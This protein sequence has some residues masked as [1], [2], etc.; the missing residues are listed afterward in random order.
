M[1]LSQGAIQDQILSWIESPG[2]QSAY[3]VTGTDGVQLQNIVTFACQVTACIAV[4]KPCGKCVGCAQALA[5]TFPDIAVA[6][7]EERTT[8]VKEIQ[9]LI[10][11]SQTTALRGRRLLVIPEAEKLSPPAVSALLKSLEEPGENTRWLLVTAYKK[12]MLKT[13]LSRCAI[14][15]LPEKKAGNK[16]SAA[17]P[18]F[19]RAKAELFREEDL[20]AVAA[21]LQ[22]HVRRQGSS[23]ALL[24]SLMRLRDF[25]K[26]RAQ[27]GN[28]KLAREVLLSTLDE[29]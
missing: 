27:R 14:L 29:L 13:I 17:L 20:R 26:I 24:K 7:G 16:P 10:F 19:N 25:Y 22:E 5:G 15:Q 4:D 23:P 21:F 8:S 9:A 12:R 2:I 6:Q 1:A 18:V 3:L 11:S 28:T